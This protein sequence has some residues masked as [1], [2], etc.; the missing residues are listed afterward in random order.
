[1]PFLSLNGRRVFYRTIGEGP[2]VIL[3]H[4]ATGSSLD[5]RLVMP[6]L[7]EA[8]YRAMAYDRPGFGQSQPVEHWPL[9][10]LQ[11]DRADLI[12]FMDVL[13]IQQAALIG[14]SDGA[15]ISLLAAASHPERVA[16]VVAESPHMWY[17][18]R[19]LPRGFQHFQE[20]LGADPRFWK[21]LERAH[22]DMAPQVVHRW[23][24]RWLDPA[25]SSWNE[26]SALPRVRCPVLIIHGA[27]DPFFPV[28][29]SQKIAEMLDDV[30]LVVL[31]NVGHTPH[32]EIV[33]D[34][35]KYI[36]SFFSDRYPA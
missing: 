13:G 27:N 12:A 22:G 3:L 29:H 33:I 5:W 1:M 9:E 30:H 32:S 23:Q 10:Y 2:P 17:E 28:E 6:R 14:N 8:G 21:V 35:T 19:S 24:E 34:Y 15:T 26:R 25:F 16:A 4:N 7:A 11:Q 36:I 31:E 20:T 18:T